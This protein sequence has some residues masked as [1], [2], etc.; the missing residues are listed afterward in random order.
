MDMDQAAVWLGG[1]ILTVLGFV[2]LVIG[3]VFINNILHKYWKPV[4]IFTPDSWKALNPPQR[5]ISQE[6][7]GKVSP[8]FDKVA[9]GFDRPIEDKQNFGKTKT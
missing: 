8:E 3:I 1:S 2:V 5:F 9:P 7:M 4:N 6:E